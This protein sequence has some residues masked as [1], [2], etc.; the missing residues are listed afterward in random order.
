VSDLRQTGKISASTL[1]VILRA[2]GNEDTYRAYLR[3]LRIDDI[4][5][6]EPP[7]P[8]RSALSEM[9]EAHGLLIFQATNCNCQIPAKAYECLRAGR[10]IFA[11][12][13]PIGD[14]AALLRSEG[15]ESIVR[16][17]SREEI[18]A[19]LMRFLETLS[20][21]EKLERHPIGGHSRKD[22]TRE[23]STLLESV[24]GAKSKTVRCN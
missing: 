2:S 10:P 15:V 24:A 22:R 17:D 6:L 16:L 23:L 9:L 19:G 3:D 18:A 21:D 12:T 5:F 11:M 8:Y 14:T 4:V 1:K 7:F 20:Q 13:D